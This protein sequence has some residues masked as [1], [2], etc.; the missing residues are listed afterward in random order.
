[1]QAISAL[2]PECSRQ[3]WYQIVNSTALIQSSKYSKIF[4]IFSKFLTRCAHICRRDTM[5]PSPLRSEIDEALDL[6]AGRWSQALE[7]RVR[8]CATGASF[9]RRLCYTLT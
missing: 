2:A 6:L 5:M 1:M 4:V 8:V 9:S 7:G 3:F